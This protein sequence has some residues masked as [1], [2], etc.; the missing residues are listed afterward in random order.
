MA[1][2]PKGVWKHKLIFVNSQERK[3][4]CSFCGEVKI[5]PSHTGKFGWACDVKDR[6]ASHPERA[7]YRKFKGG[8]CER[9][10]FV[11]ENGIQLDVH[12]ID[13]NHSNNNSKNL[14]TLCAN[15]HRL[16]SLFS[17]N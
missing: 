10:G 1:Y 6:E 11:A 8:K 13:R 12:H 15:C 7:E 17:K 2:S 16:E 5:R 3:G 4:L 9:C 14:M